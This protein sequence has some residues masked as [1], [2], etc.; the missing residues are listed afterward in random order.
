[1]TAFGNNAKKNGT[2]SAI[3]LHVAEPEVL[4]IYNTFTWEA[5]ADKKKVSKIIK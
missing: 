5:E 3:L 1:M 4:E 2:K